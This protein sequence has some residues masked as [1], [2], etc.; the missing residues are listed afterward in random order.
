MIF[1]VLRF[2]LQESLP[3][4]N[5]DIVG[6]VCESADFI[7]KDR[8]L[9]IAVG[10]YLAIDS[11]GAYG[12]AMSSNYNTRP[13]AVEIMVDKNEINIIRK[14]EVVSELFAKESLLPSTS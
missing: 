1:Y 8:A 2:N 7:G 5:F 6:P 3:V 14:R 13:R 4:K 12:S 11:A 10:D 9:A